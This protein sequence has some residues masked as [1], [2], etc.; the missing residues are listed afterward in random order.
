M[1]TGIFDIDNWREIGATLSRNKT[2]TFL[3]AFG[4]FW[5]TAML[6]ILWGGA[7]G[8]KGMLMRNVEGLATNMA[9]VEPSRT[10]MPYKGYNKG[11]KVKIEQEDLDA[12]RRRVPH[13]DA[14][15]GVVMR[16]VNLAYNNKSK[17][18][19]ACKGI[20]AGYYDIEYPILYKGRLINESDIRERRKVVNIGKNIAQELF[21]SEDIEGK[22]LSINGIYFQIVGIVGQ[23]GEFSIGG[24]SDD[25]VILPENVMRSALGL[26]REIDFV[27]FTADPGY[28]PDD[29]RP[30]LM[31]VL[32]SRHPIHPEDDNAIRM[33]NIA[34]QFRMVDNIFLGVSLL[35]LFVGI[36]TLMAG[37][38]GV[39]NIM[40]II[41]KERTQEIG[42]R[43]AIGAKPRDIIVQVLSEGIALTAIAGIAGISFATL[44]L[45]VVDK[46][47]YDPISGS[48]QFLLTFEH[49]VQ[50]MLI[51]LVLGI[52]AGLIPSV[53]AMKIKPIEAMREGK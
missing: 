7:S 18:G 47:T 17:N 40:W 15:S 42:I 31:R 28:D 27:I 21:G 37:I 39:G 2:R 53:K 3:T 51:F 46:A 49:A 32:K 36:G 16:V 24:K 50:I 43:R 13:I 35:A 8:L 6:G 14:L 34:E 38:I 9:V 22:F 44:V 41:V 20:E 4:I 23:N 33:M 5:G 26:G 30:S 48:A 11:M 10:S 52:I 12:V 29:V 45:Y 25:S 1:R 19:V